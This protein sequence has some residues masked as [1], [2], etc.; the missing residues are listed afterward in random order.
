M[1]LLLLCIVGNKQQPTHNDAT[2]PRASEREK[3][4]RV[5]DEQINIKKQMKLKWKY[6]YYKSV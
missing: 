1:R 5:F 6:I 2:V 4:V 3:K